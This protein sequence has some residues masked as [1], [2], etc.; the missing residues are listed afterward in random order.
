MRSMTTLLMHTVAH[1]TRHSFRPKTN[2]HPIKKVFRSCGQLSKSPQKL[3]VNIL[4]FLTTFTQ[5]TA[6]LKNFLVGWLLIIGLKE[7]LVECVT[8]CV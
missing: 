1:F 3:D 8:V 4:P 5:V 6:R 2:N 7:C